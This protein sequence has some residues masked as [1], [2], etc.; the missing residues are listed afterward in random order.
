[1]SDM[2]HAIVY[3]ADIHYRP[4]APEG[5]SSIIKV[6]LD[7]VKE[8]I[9]R[10]SEHKFFIAFAGDIAQA[11]SQPGVYDSFAR[12]VDSRLSEMGLARDARLVVPGNHD[13][14]RDL[15]AGFLQEYKDIHEERS[16]TEPAFNDF[17]STS[18]ELHAKFDN[19]AKFLAC[20][21]EHNDELCRTGWGRQI[22]DDISVYC[23]NSALCSFGGL[24]KINDEGQLAIYTR[25]LVDWCN[26][27]PTNNNILLLHHP[28]D[29]LNTW[30]RTELQILIEKHFTICLCGHNHRPE[31]YH[32]KIPQNAMICTSPPLFCGKEATL[33]YSILLLE[34]GQPTSLVYREYSGG[35]FFPGASISKTNDGVVKLGTDYVRYLREIESTLQSALNS[36]KGQPN[37][38]VEPTISESRAFSDAP[39]LLNDIIE[40]PRDA[41]IV[42]P[43]QFGLTCLSLYMRLQ[44]YRQKKF[45]IYIDGAHVKARKIQR[46]IENEVQHYEKSTADLECIMVDGWDPDVQD[47]SNM[48]QQIHDAHPDVPV[49]LFTNDKAFLE[50]TYDLSKVDR[51]FEVLHLQALNRLAMRQLV[52]EYTRSKPVGNE[53]DLHAH[54]AIHMEAIN[55]HRTPLNCLTLLRVL[56]SSYS[57]KL[58]NKTK[59]MKAILFV[60]FTDYESFS[61]TSKS[62]GVDECTYALG[63]YCKHLVEQGE[64]SFDSREFVTALKSICKEGLI[65]LDVD[66]MVNVLLE[67]SILVQYGTDFEFK[68]RC[69]VFFFAANNMLHD[70][71]FRS[72]IL[73]QRRYVN[74]PEIIDFFAG[75][76]GKR[77]DA[78]R[79]L[80]A[81]LKLLI[82]EVDSKIGIEG[83]F[84]PLSALLWNPSDEFIEETRRQ[85]AEK[86]ESSNLPP[87]IKDKQAD[88]HYDSVAPYD[89]SIRK[90]LNEYSVTSLLC[91][92]C[93]LSRALRNSTFV[94]PEL[95][96]EVSEVILNGWEEISK[97][98]FWLTPL[99]AKDGK[100]LHDGLHVVLADGFSKDLNKRFCEILAANPENIV[101]R[102]KDDLVSNNVGLLLTE[103]LTKNESYLQK[104][105]VALFLIA[106]RPDGWFQPLLEHLNRLHPR[107]FYLGNL[108][109]ALEHEV[110]LGFLKGRD[111]ALLKRLVGA[112]LAKRSYMPKKSVK[113]SRKPIPSHSLLCDSNKLHLD[114]LLSK[115]RPTPAGAFRSKNSGDGPR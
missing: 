47:H 55:I 109:T 106:V 25:G 114:K 108:L 84:N 44:A 29:H 69:W 112:V 31:V 113:Q 65:P 5:A 107:S 71:E 23:L 64:R 86:V 85:I 1:M 21:A 83:P 58:L 27:K 67:N 33:A 28:L 56:D 96:L 94:K 95:K 72:Y 7:D 43:P 30:S 110:K 63:R 51:T 97:I 82:K 60:L 80:L 15:V 102:L 98:L 49:L 37:V 17:M 4:E 54:M 19:Y 59:L 48:L 91:S 10:L 66:A 26:N 9:V 111:E 104:H 3:V 46:F 73:E 52:S 50:S 90:F 101:G 61:H 8:Q 24:E 14:D 70:D 32:Q 35:K 87:A 39:N 11:G 20:F 105:F 74:F 36:F 22:A 93:A 45:W 57:E 103:Q 78:L 92:I 62:P 53:D 42:A 115:H 76:D 18:N 75:I 77:D 12:E 81:D 34:D 68:H 13:L 88:K 89:Q 40:S 16:K 6:L 99:L 100:A 41:L 38:F 79:N 2:K